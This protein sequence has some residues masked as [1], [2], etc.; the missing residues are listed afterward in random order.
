MKQAFIK[1][2]SLIAAFVV[3]LGLTSAGVHAEQAKRSPRIHLAAGGNPAVCKANFDQCYAACDHMSG[4]E[5]QCSA[6][7]RACLGQ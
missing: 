5:N 1:C 4:C 3:V 2:A 6:N 7:Y